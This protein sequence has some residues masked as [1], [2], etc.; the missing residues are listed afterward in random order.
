MESFAGAFGAERPLLGGQALVAT[1][2]AISLA[3]S[4][5]EAGFTGIHAQPIVPAEPFLAVRAF[6]R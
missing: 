6:L 2:S 1:A 5:S 3:K 4:S